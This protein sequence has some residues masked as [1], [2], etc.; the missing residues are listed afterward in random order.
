MRIRWE[1]YVARMGEGR[2]AYRISLGKPEGKK[3]LGRPDTYARRLL[4][5]ILKNQ[6]EGVYWI[7]LARG[8]FRP[9]QTR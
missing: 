4:E 1:E 5:L 6:V 3:P 2:G 9:R 8:E 7:D